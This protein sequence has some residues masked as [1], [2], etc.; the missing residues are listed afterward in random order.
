MVAIGVLSGQFV[1]VTGDTM[2]GDLILSSGADLQAQD[3][4]FVGDDLD[5]S[6]SITGP[7]ITALEAE[8]AALQAEIDALVLQIALI[9]T[10][11]SDL[12]AADVALDA[13]LDFIEPAVATLQATVATHTTQI[14]TIQGQIST[15]QGQISALQTA[16]T[17]T[18]AELDALE[19][20]VVFLDPTSGGTYLGNTFTVPP[21]PAA[22]V[23]WLRSAVIPFSVNDS[24]FDI[25]RLRATDEFG[26]TVNTN[27]WNGNAE[28][29][30]RPSARN[31]VADRVF[32]SAESVGGSTDQYVQWSS[33]AAVREPFLGGWGS[34]SP[35]PGW[36]EGTR[37]ISGLQGISAG[38]TVNAAL[39]PYNTLT[40]LVFRGFKTGL[41]PPAAGTWALNDVVIDVG[42]AAWRC[43]VAGTPG[44]WTGGSSDFT[45]VTNLNAGLS[46]GSTPC[47]TSLIE[48]G[49]A[50]RMRGFLTVGGASIAA[51]TVLCRIGLAGH[52]PLHVVRTGIR[53]SG[54][55]NRVQVALNGDVSIAVLLNANDDVWFDSLTYD[56]RT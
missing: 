24:N 32:E 28:G 4:V 50:V 13:R 19:T 26:N 11:I 17:A 45:T 22:T 23:P 38:G 27:T 35:K 12:Q 6:G 7:T 56:L 8:S 46:L 10:Q 16:Q 1:S 14:S 40:G 29:R 20:N 33:D 15:I 53:Y 31:R 44:T 5:V 36:V 42:G 39:A 21:N 49:R 48:N 2:T 47:A 43:T 41:G 51:N 25:F 3:D 18:Q 9:N 30:R 34:A 55:G 52:I 54:G 37:V